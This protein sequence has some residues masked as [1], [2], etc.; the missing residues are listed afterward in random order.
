MWRINYI[1]MRIADFVNRKTITKTVNVVTRTVP[2]DIFSKPNITSYSFRI[3]YIRQLCINFN[4][5]EFVKQTID[6]RNLNTT[7]YF[8]LRLKIL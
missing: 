7:Y 5:I 3:V 6:N 2:E 1:I 4:N 8:G